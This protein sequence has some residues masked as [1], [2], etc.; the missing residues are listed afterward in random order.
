MR[1]LLAAFVA[2][3]CLDAISAQCQPGFGLASYYGSNMVLQR[4]PARP[5]IWGYASAVGL[6]IIVNLNPGAQTVFVNSVMGPD[7][8]PTWEI[9]LQ[10]IMTGGAHTIT[11]QEGP[12]CVLTL[13]NVLIG[14]IWV[15]SGQSNMEMSLQQID[16]PQ[17]DID[18]VVNYQMVRTLHAHNQESNVP[19]NDL[20]SVR[21]WAMPTPGQISGFSAICWLFGRNLF[22]KH[23]RPIGLIDATW[24]GTRI[25]AWSG[26]DALSVCALE[27]SEQDPNDASALWNAMIHPLLSFP[28]YGA[29]WY[30][31]ESNSGNP[32]YACFI[33][34]MVADWRNKWNQRNP[35]MDPLFPFGQVQLA[36]WRNQDIESGFTEVR[37]AQT[38]SFGYTPN[39]NMPKFFMACAI[40]L[41]DFTSPAGDIHPRYKRQIAHRLALAAFNVAYDDTDTGIY[42]GPIPT[43]YSRDGNN[44]RISYGLALQFRTTNTPGMFELCCGASAANTC[45]NAGGRWVVTSFIQGGTMD[46]TLTNP[47]SPTESVTG[48]RFLW[49]E[50][51]CRILES[52]PVYSVENSLPAPPYVHH[53]NIARG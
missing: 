31:G 48:F 39:A 49:R 15:C 17:P 22:I 35:E 18:D 53:G 45:N 13:T 37:W 32:A 2:L 43:G 6:Q 24:G 34:A 16:N 20:R 50:S 10:P 4:P 41:P 1:S 25:E 46:M 28:I 36:P 51:P 52:C 5:R 23:G 29:I 7:G 27:K 12:N 38:D 19:L 40:D 11:V 14:D 30:Q 42:Q 44:V 9:L 26:P 3:A 33:K 21:N 47:C 8:R